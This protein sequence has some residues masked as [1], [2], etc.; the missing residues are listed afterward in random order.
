MSERASNHTMGRLDWSGHGGWE[1]RVRGRARLQAPR[2]GPGTGRVQG[3]D[4]RSR[5]NLDSRATQDEAAR[6]EWWKRYGDPEL[7]ALESRVDVSNQTIQQADAQFRQARAVLHEDR[8]QYYPTVTVNP[9]ITR[10]RVSS[11]RSDQV[12]RA[13][14]T[15]AFSLPVDA[16]Y[17]ADVWGRIGRRSRGDALTRKRARRTSSPSG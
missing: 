3:S 16:S 11:T 15:T 1:R 2:G 8:S 13:T 6:G 9:A 7:D 17:E 5:R 14:S 10:Q 4:R 12:V